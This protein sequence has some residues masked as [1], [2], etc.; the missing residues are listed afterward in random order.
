MKTKLYFLMILLLP[1]HLTFAGNKWDG[2]HTKEKTIKKE[3]T[4][5]QDALLKIS[6]S[7]GNINIITYSGNTVRIEVNIK[8]NGNNLDKV[9]EKLDNITVD[10]HA[11][12]TLVSAKTIFDKNK[13]GSWWNWGRNTNVNMEINYLIK[14][15][16]SN[17][18]DLSNDY[19]SINLDRLEGHAKINCDYGK[20][21]T[22]ELMADN[23]LISFDYTNNSYFEFIKSGKI[24]ADYSSFTVAKTKDL[25]INADYTK[26][27]VEIAENVSYT[28]DY[29]SVTVEKANN[30]K[31]NGDYLTARFGEIYKNIQIAADYG[32]IKID[33]MTKNAGNVSIDSDFT[34]ITIG[35][36]FGYQFKFDI[37]LEYASLRGAEDFQF[38]KK[39]AESN[40]K[41][42]QGYQGD[43]NA[44][45]LI[46]ITSDYGSVTFKRN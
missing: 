20:I 33:R 11:S 30:V 26:S 34:V 18:V 8:T 29:G 43:A 12:S 3:Y 22:K 32:S 14:L 23:N 16:M 42:Y 40:D 44:K 31:G 5:N 39:K 10:F 24:N 2:R 17:S 45:N 1:F 9:Q 41:L 38:I 35:Y 6:N 27:V 4:V 46:K 36:D 19:G 28:C 13:S 37:K 15:P 21:T 25:D 7:Y